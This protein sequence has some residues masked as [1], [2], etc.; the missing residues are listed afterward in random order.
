VD[1]VLTP[2]LLLPLD[3]LHD[4]VAGQV[5][6]ELLLVDA[7]RLVV[8]EEAG[9]LKGEFESSCEPMRVPWRRWS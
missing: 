9:Q 5:L 2:V 6:T 4:F 7:D 8:P 3:Q 1:A